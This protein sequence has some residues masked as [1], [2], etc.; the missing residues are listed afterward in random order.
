M[1]SSDLKYELFVRFS[2]STKMVTYLGSG[3]P[4][5]YHGPRESAVHDLLEPRDASLSCT[6]PALNPL[7]TMLRDFIDDR[8]MGAGAA[9]NAL[10]LAQTDFMLS[11][12]RLKFWDAIREPLPA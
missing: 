10:A 2:L 9:R 12:I 6:E 1:C 11:D 7:I 8:E 5:L 3:I 4:I